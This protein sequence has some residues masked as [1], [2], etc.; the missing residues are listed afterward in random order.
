MS[1]GW[2]ASQRY[3]VSSGARRPGAGPGLPQ[4]ASASRDT[5]RTCWP[6]RRSRG[7]WAAGAVRTWSAL[8]G[9]DVQP[10]ALDDAD[11]AKLRAL[12]DHDRE[13]WCA[14]EAAERA[15]R[16][17]PFPHP[18]RCP[19]PARCGWNPAAPAG[20]GWPRRCGARSLLSQHARHLAT[21]QAMPQPPLRVDVLR[22]LE[23]QQRGVARRQDVR[24]R[25]E[26]ARVPGPPTRTRARDGL[27]GFA[28]V[29]GIG[30][31]G[32]ATRR[33][34]Q[35]STPLCMSV[36]LARL[37]VARFSAPPATRRRRGP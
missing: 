11:L 5:A 3:G 14:G 10:P 25:R 28:A 33:R 7:D 2:S 16:R 26:P 19:T 27:S 17:P 34:Q 9:V 15:Q 18:L 13:R 35:R 1:S 4:H 20:A 29:G 6:T 8:R 36:T 24:Q 37:G 12:R 22:P 21:D 31:R 30:G 23:E 32:P